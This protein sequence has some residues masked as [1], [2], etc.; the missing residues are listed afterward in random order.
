MSDVIWI[1]LCLFL[2]VVLIYELYD[3]YKISKSRKE[4]QIKVLDYLDRILKKMR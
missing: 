1:I 4:F 2:I 3:S